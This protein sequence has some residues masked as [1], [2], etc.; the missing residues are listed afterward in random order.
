MAGLMLGLAAWAQQGVPVR[1]VFRFPTQLAEI[2]GLEQSRTQ[3][4]VY[5]VHNDSG[6]QPRVYAVVDGKLVGTYTL[7][8]AKAVDWEDMSIGPAP[9][10]AYLYL[11]DIGDNTGKRESVTIYRVAEPK[12][13][14]TAGRPEERV[15]S[16]VVAYEFVYEDGPRD[17]EGFFVDPRTGD[18]YVVT[19]RELDGNRLYQ[20]EA[21]ALK[22][23]GANTL[24]RVATMGF[25]LSTGA[26]IS[27]DGLQVIVRRYSS[28]TNPLMPPSI[29]ATYWRRASVKMSIAEMMS[30]PGT[31]LPLVP[32]VQGEA[33]AFGADG[34]GFYSTGERGAGATAMDAAL[35]YYALPKQ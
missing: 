31:V 11:A 15:L 29:A 20:A 9:R 7:A 21:K 12:V 32:E 6:D 14:G 35:T 19:K 26:A 23:K 25:T 33:I 5:W 18:F 17:A 28:A 3:P 1:E 30:Q 24:R 2:S 16:G 4:A 34:K 13:K 8:G 10:G 22:T 27:A